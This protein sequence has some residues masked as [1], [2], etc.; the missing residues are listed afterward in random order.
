M[1]GEPWGDFSMQVDRA[2]R[3]VPGAAGI[4]KIACGAFHNLA[5]TRCPAPPAR[6]PAAHASCQIMPA[7][8]AKLTPL[9][10]GTSRA[11]HWVEDAPGAARVSACSPH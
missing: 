5:L 4:A 11:M 8:G 9:G 6:L 10:L 1:W 2:P 7:P 3:K